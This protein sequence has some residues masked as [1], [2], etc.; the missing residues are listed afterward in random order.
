MERHN[1]PRTWGFAPTGNDYGGPSGIN[2]GF[3]PAQAFQ[4]PPTQRGG[5]GRGRGGKRPPPSQP[6][7]PVSERSVEKPEVPKPQHL[8]KTS[9]E[10]KNDPLYEEA[11][12][13]GPS[14]ELREISH[15]KKI[16]PSCDGLMALVEELYL[17]M[18]ARSF[19][20]KRNV[21]LAAHSYYFAVLTYARIL[22]LHIMNKRP[23]IY[24]EDQFVE[25]IMER[26]NFDVPSSFA[27][28]LA[29]YGNTTLP[30]GVKQWFTLNKPTL[31]NPQQGIQGYFGPIEINPGAYASYPCIAVFAQR[32]ME[33]LRFTANQGNPDWDLPAQFAFA[34]HPINANCIGYQPAVR[35]GQDQVS[36]LA[37]KGITN[38]DFGTNND[39]IALNLTLLNGVQ[40]FMNEIPGLRALPCPTNET[41]SQGQLVSV[42]VEHFNRVRDRN[43]YVAKAPLKIVGSIAYLGSSFL[44]KL[45]KDGLTF[46]QIRNLLP[47]D[48]QAG[49]NPPAAYRDSVCL[50]NQDIDEKLD[51]YDY[52][53]TP[54]QL[55]LR[56]KSITSKDVTVKNG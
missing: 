34:Q 12:F 11:F 33:D 45:R 22:H 46:G 4:R 31:G 49:V 18:T 29:G 1:N 47:N 8:S 17:E 14:D 35:L 36:F 41:G 21:S 56:M 10:L 48:F 23:V 44:Y 53:S 5:R 24:D 40:K 26:G 39:S 43:S 7:F 25:Q 28:Y 32:I 27:K 42:V 30:S 6:G 13:P 37:T 3:M 20:Y 52:E 2:N 9:S 55:P 50:N 54:F 38:N 15:E 51:V 16:F 19:N